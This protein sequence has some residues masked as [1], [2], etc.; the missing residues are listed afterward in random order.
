MHWECARV[1][2]SESAAISLPSSSVSL[3]FSGV[4]APFCFL[5]VFDLIN[6][7]Q[8]ILQINSVLVSFIHLN[9]DH[10]N[11][12]FKSVPMSLSL[13]MRISG[14]TLFRKPNPTTVPRAPLYIPM[15]LLISAIVT[16]RVVLRTY[17]RCHVNS[18]PYPWPNSQVYEW[19]W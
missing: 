16:T 13:G 2:P 17:I 6:A 7:L 11:F 19:Q 14:G 18:A 1:C 15:K 4:R 9:K 5:A 8:H 3:T 12:S 10:R